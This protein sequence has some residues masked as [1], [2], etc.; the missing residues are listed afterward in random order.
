MVL[1]AWFIRKVQAVLCWD[2]QHAHSG[3]PGSCCLHQAGPVFGAEL[4][5]LQTL[6][7]P[8]WSGWECAG[9]VGGLIQHLVNTSFPGIN[10]LLKITEILR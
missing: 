1:D 7:S 10:Y 8:V 5:E 2:L 6:G 9:L 4:H 3:H